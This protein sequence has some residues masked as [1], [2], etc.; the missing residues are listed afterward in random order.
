MGK[1]AGDLLRI[2]TCDRTFQVAFPQSLCRAIEVPPARS[3]VRHIGTTDASLFASSL[4]RR[5]MSLSSRSHRER[6]RF[7]CYASP[8]NALGRTCS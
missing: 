8:V 7:E 6:Q 2:Y 1:I 3:A 4:P 5:N